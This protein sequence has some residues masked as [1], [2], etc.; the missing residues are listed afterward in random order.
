MEK[1]RYLITLENEN[2]DIISNFEMAFNNR[3]TILNNNVKN[4]LKEL[5]VSECN[6][7]NWKNSGISKV[8][9]KDDLNRIR[10]ILH[11]QGE[12]L[13]SDKIE[14]KKVENSHLVEIILS[15]NTR[16]N[17]DSKYD[18]SITTLSH[19]IDTLFNII[20]DIFMDI[21]MFHLFGLENKFNSVEEKRYFSKLKTNF[22]ND[23]KLNSYLG[24]ACK[25]HEYCSLAFFARSDNGI[26]YTKYIELW[27]L[28][29]AEYIYPKKETKD[30]VQ[31]IILDKCNGVFQLSKVKLRNSLEEEYIG[32]LYFIARVC[33]KPKNEM[34][35]KHL[36]ALFV[37]KN[38]KIGHIKVLPIIELPKYKKSRFIRT[39]VFEV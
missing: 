21:N 38:V 25:F 6:F 24:D 13:N 29:L 23:K 31:N 28:F 11:L 9:F 15:N 2:N 7:Y 33:K 8:A 39:V 5:K 37:G 30:Y 18:L 20:I 17:D 4:L 16:I 19:D 35:I 10:I 12:N 22:C 27:K 32:G 14:E 1:E 26:N 3:K 34:D 36:D